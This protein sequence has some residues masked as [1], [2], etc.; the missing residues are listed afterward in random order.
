MFLKLLLKASFCFLFKMFVL[1][2]KLSFWP[3]PVSELANTGSRFPFPFFK[4]PSSIKLIVTGM[5]SSLCSIGTIT[6]FINSTSVLSEA[7]II[8]SFSLIENS[9]SSFS[10]PIIISRIV[11]TNSSIVA[12][13]IPSLSN[14]GASS[15]FVLRK[16]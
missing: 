15:S 8:S 4:L 10:P 14:L 11:L 3:D 7:L 13:E 6:L 16:A 1:K 9:S 12:F 5:R 2:K